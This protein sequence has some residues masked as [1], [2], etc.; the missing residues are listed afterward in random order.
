MVFLLEVLSGVK[1]VNSPEVSNHV[2]CPT[3]DVASLDSLSFLQ[4][5]DVSMITVKM[6]L[7]VFKSA[8]LM[9]AN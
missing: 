5:V 3:S 6:Y 9:R 2:Q 1:L 4:L 8:E 7:S